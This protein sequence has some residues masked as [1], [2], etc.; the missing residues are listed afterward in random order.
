MHN[1][2]WKK[3]WKLKLFH[4]SARLLRGLRPAARVI[5][6]VLPAAGLVTC[7]AGVASLFRFGLPTG[8]RVR[9][10]M[11]AV[12]IAASCAL[13]ETGHVM[14][15]VACGCPVY[16]TGLWMKGPI[17]QGAYVNMRRVAHSRQQVQ[18]SLAGIESD[19]LFSGC[20]LL[21]G[22]LQ[23]RADCCVL[24]L[25]VLTLGLGNLLPDD[26]KDGN[27]ALS[28]LLRVD[29][30]AV[31]AQ[32]VL[33]SAE[34]RRRLRRQPYGHLA[35]AILVLVRCTKVLSVVLVMAAGGLAAYMIA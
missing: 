26:G 21:K 23:Q 4:P 12:G 34:R 6:A 7:A 29:N 27:D 32:N 25:L 14:A 3:E 18:M 13:H 19:L 1:I 20:F 24:G 5:N 22:A 2:N 17:V 8:S 11:W 28:D 9:L 30:A 16:D 15:A 10:L 35:L 31:L 33:G